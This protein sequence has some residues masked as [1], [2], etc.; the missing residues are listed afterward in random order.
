MDLDALMKEAEGGDDDALIAAI[1]ASLV[2]NYKRGR[3]SIVVSP[4]VVCVARATDDF[5]M[6]AAIP[7][8][9]PIIPGEIDWLSALPTLDAV[10]GSTGRA[11]RLEVI[12]ERFPGLAE[13]LIAY[14]VPE[15]TAPAPVLAMTEPPEPT[16]S[17]G[18]TDGVEISLIPAGDAQAVDEY[19]AV[20]QAA[21]EHWVTPDGLAFWR[22]LVRRT[23]DTETGRAAIARQAGVPVGCGMVY[24]HHP[25]AELLGVGTVPAARRQGIAAALCTALVDDHFARLPSVPLWLSAGDDGAHTLYEKLGFY[26]A[27]TQRNFGRQPPKAQGPIRPS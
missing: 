10:M 6:S 27:A 2:A 21:F 14:G 13:A 25:A 4:F 20:G 23:I 18:R 17:P 11:L 9:A 26:R 1:A 16:A 22:A 24:G 12:E 19:M 5:L 7:S 3:D 8:V 15:V